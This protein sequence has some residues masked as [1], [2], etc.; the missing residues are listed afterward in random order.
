MSSPDQEHLD[1]ISGSLI[2]LQRRQDELESRVRQ[3]ESALRVSTQAA[4][5]AVPPPLP[6]ADFAAQPG[7]PGPPTLPTITPPAPSPIYV[8]IGAD[9]H[10]DIG[11]ESTTAPPPMP[12]MQME[13]QPHLKTQPELETQVGL[14]WINRVA[15]VTLI[16]AAAFFFRYAVDAGWIG[17]ATRVAL[18][19]MAA[20]VSLFFGDRM[21]R[22]GHAIFAQGL[23]GLGIALL[24]L[25]L[26]ELRAVCATPAERGLLSDDADHR[27]VG[28]DGIAVQFASHRD[29]GVAG[30]IPDTGFAL[31]RRR[32]PLVPVWLH[33]RP[34]H[35]RVGA[36]PR[37]RLAVDRIPQ[38]GRDSDPVF[39]LVREV[40]WRRGSDRGHHLRDRL[41]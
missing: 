8:D 4:S 33:V 32:P 26:R 38:R 13:V 25:L 17:P 14:N 20:I 35:R 39:R 1:A 15:V 31:D 11:A 40:V 18:G 10:A 34:E 28:P 19:V 2:R 23:M 41:L 12:A 30:R 22:R 5:P 27:C 21:W 29:A 6:G 7:S 37:A 3:L 9:I 36:H 24:S 16:F